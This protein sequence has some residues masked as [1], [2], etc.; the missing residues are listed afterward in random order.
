MYSSYVFNKFWTFFQ[1]H[2]VIVIIVLLLCYYAIAV[3]FGHYMT[4]VEISDRLL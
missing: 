1:V 3:Y 4:G 2:I